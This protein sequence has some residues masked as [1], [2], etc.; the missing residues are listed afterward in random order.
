MSNAI[1]LTR[2]DIQTITRRVTEQSD[3]ITYGVKVPEDEQERIS[4]GAPLIWVQ[5]QNLEYQYIDSAEDDGVVDEVFYEAG[6][7][8][9]SLIDANEA[10][11]VDHYHFPKDEGEPLSLED[12]RVGLSRAVL[13]DLSSAWVA[14]IRS[15]IEEVCGEDP[16]GGGDGLT[17]P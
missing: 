4:K 2:E 9:D 17:F 10:L 8:I 12:F 11:K 13:S 15:V 7:D 1:T 14:L 16:L 5:V 3:S 6:L